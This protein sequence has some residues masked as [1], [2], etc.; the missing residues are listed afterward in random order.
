MSN[1]F[2][3][4]IGRKLI[5]SV[6]GIFLILFLLFHMSMNIAAIFSAEAYNMICELLGANWYAV[7]ATLVLVAGVLVHIIYAIVLT[8]MN[9]KARGS[10]RY[11]VSTREKGV[12]WSSKNMLVIG[13]V[14]LFGLLIHGYQFWYNM[15]F[16]ELI[17]GHTNSVGLSAH[18]GAGLIK[19]YFTQPAYVALYLVW[20][21]AIWFHLTHGF[22]SMFQ[23]IGWANT[24]WLPRLKCIANIFATIVFLGFAAVVLATFFSNCPMCA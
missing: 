23:T 18:D 15:M 24:I 6:S 21:A 16:V 8:I 20:F 9:R 4:S 14:V 2:T 3:S 7:A 13:F 11:A 12:S 10:Q 5:M 19:F 1:L 22:W 17:G